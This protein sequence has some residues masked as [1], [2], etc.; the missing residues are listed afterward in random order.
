MTE[1]KNGAK[2]I[3][4]EPPL[5]TESTS[6]SLGGRIIDYLAYLKETLNF[7]FYNY[8]RR[9]T[10]ATG[11]INE[12]VR[13]AAETTS[14]LENAEGA[15][16]E[17]SQKADKI[18]ISVAGKVDED[19]VISAINASPE[20]ITIASNKISLNGTTIVNGKIVA[21]YT[22]TYKPSDYSQADLDKARNYVLG[23]VSLT[24]EEFDKYD[25]NFDGSIK[26]SD[27]VIIRNMING[28]RGPITKTVT[29]TIDPSAGGR[30]IV[31]D[32]VV[33]GNTV[34][35]SVY[36]G[37]KADTPRVVADYIYPLRSRHSIG[38]FVYE[39]GTSNGWDYCKWN[40]GLVEC[41]LKRRIA[42]ADIANKTTWGTM[43]V[44]DISPVS[45][46]V[47]FS[48]PPHEIVSPVG[49]NSGTAYE[50]SFWIVDYGGDTG[51][52]NSQS[53]KYQAVRPAAFGSGITIEYH[54]VGKTT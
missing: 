26:M 22:K 20:Q 36:D 28:D 4:R 29:T 2:Y 18:E 49:Y 33:G 52:S 15:I 19:S 41:W 11:N 45:Y 30:A 23:T 32:S 34:A 6:R 31:V 13:T 21:S 47:V 3:D 40:S 27:V 16:S 43:Y 39:R 17:I 38:D 14:R 5:E 42:L 12:V 37:I 9:L 35:H 46:P 1:T 53:G 54:V 8:G 44:G 50:N 7:I 24:E 51:P 25:L 48:E 10:D